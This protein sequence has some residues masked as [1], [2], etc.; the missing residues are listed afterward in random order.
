MHFRNIFIS[1]HTIKM[2][3]EAKQPR[4]YALLRTDELKLLNEINQLENKND[5][6]KHIVLIT[7]YGLDVWLRVI[8]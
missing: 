4:L 7:K 1:P 3:L 8:K 5:V 6:N 2:I